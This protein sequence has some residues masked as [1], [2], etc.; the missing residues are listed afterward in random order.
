VP[1]AFT[2]YNSDGINDVFKPKLIGVHDYR[3]MIFNRWG[4]K[5]FE[6]TDRE[7]GWDGYVKGN[8]CQQDVYVYKIIFKDDVQLQSH[9]Y[10]GK[11]IL[12]K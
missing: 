7:L 10:V 2:P 8:L 11:V 5:I 4:D 3:F 9:E 6:T 1:N 12:V